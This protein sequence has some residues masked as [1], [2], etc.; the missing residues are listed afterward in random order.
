MVLSIRSEECKGAAAS[1][2]T[3]RW[4]V[5]LSSVATDAEGDETVVI[6]GRLHPDVFP[7]I[8]SFCDLYDAEPWSVGTQLVTRALFDTGIPVAYQ[9]WLARVF[10][11]SRVEP[12]LYQLLHAA[13]FLQ[14]QPLVELCCAKLA[15]LLMCLTVDDRAK[16]L[17]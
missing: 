6:P 9:D 15:T 17:G 5:L 12:I 4:S 8:N 14:I 10:P 3:V 16:L 13:N 2:A 7:L 11:E 1:A